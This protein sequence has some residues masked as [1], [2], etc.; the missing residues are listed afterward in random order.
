MKLFLRSATA[1]S[2]ILI[3]CGTAAAEQELNFKLGAHAFFDYENVS[4]NDDTVVEGT[5]LKLFRIDAG[6]SYGDYTFKSNVD[7]GN[8]DVKVKDL[9]I[10]IK[11]ETSIRF[12]NFKVMN[13]LEQSSS[14]YSTTFAEANSVSKANKLSRQLGVGVFRNFDNVFLSAGVFGADVN[15]TSDKDE[16][17]VSGRIAGEFQPAENAG[18][19]HLG[20]SVR[21]RNN[22][23]ESRDSYAQKPFASSAPTTVKASGFAETDTFLGLEAAYLNGGLSLQ[24]EYG[25]TSADCE[26]EGCSGDVNL[27]T[28]YADVSYIWGGERVLKNGLF[29]RTKIYNPAGEGGSGAFALSARFDVADLNDQMIMGGKQESVVLGGTWY[30]D[31]Y[32]RVLFNYTH[33]DFEDSPSFGDGSADTFV[34]RLQAELY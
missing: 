14:L 33:A 13:G 10:E 24:S 8:D 25:L 16:W 5:N 21:Y 4:V 20:S 12:G 17:S 9:F 29:K 1:L 7:F 28:W 2:A 32:V 26:A 19:L 31:K 22:S 6:G 34:V 11:G 30:R 23:D 18:K 27:N 15:D 3:S